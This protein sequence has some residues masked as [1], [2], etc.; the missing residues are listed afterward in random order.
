M[1]LL[2]KV[3]IPVKSSLL[4]FLPW[5]QTTD[6]ILDLPSFTVTL[7]QLL[8]PENL[9]YKRNNNVITAL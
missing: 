1:F 5:N 9:I 4:L 8:N 6:Q 2:P 3:L 7:V